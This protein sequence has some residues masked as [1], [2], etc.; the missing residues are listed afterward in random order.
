MATELVFRFR[1]LLRP[2]L[3]GYNC[4]LI[5]SGVY[6]L[7]DIFFQTFKDLVVTKCLEEFSR[8]YLNILSELAIIVLSQ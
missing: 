6:F 7:F 3:L 8:H 2:R 4:H 5:I 1:M